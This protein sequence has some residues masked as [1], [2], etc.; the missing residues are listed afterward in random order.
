M[1]GR[2]PEA[3]G[4]EDGD[5]QQQRGDG[6]VD[7][8]CAAAT[9]VMS[10]TRTIAATTRAADSEPHA[11]NDRTYLEA[12][13]YR[14]CGSDERTALTDAVADDLRAAAPTS[15]SS[16][17]R[18]ATTC[19]GPKWDGGS[20]SSVA[21]ATADTGVLFCWTGTGAS[22]AANKVA[23]RTGRAVHRCRRPPRARAGGTT[24]TCW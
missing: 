13:A 21:T 4:R 15:C 14:R 1:P 18:P 11:Q 22:I 6:Q 8:E 23:G 9:S 5:E 24:R 16:V 17:R 7:V 19:S 10:A 2:E 12:H 3:A 20:G